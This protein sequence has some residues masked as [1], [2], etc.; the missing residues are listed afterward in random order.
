MSDKS[1]EI[2]F[3][4]VYPVKL[5]LG[6]LVF[7][8]NFFVFVIFASKRKRTSSD[9][10]IIPNLL[11]DFLH[12]AGMCIPLYVLSS[13]KEKMML[14]AFFFQVLMF[15]SLIM[16][17][18][19]TLNRYT[20]VLRPMKYKIWFA[21]T[22]MLST[23][24][25]VSAVT[26]FLFAAFAYA[27]FLG[28]MDK[29]IYKKV[30][31]RTISRSLSQP[32]THFRKRYTLDD[33]FGNNSISYDGYWNPPIAYQA[34]ENCHLKHFGKRK[35]AIL[36][37]KVFVYYIWPQFQLLLVSLNTL[38]MCFVYKKISNHFKNRVKLGLFGRFVNLVKNV[39]LD[40]ESENK[41]QCR[42]GSAGYQETNLSQVTKE[43]TKLE[44]IGEAAILT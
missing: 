8:A 27:L 33:L 35:T 25:A 29:Q 4:A 21:K 6:V 2:I 19:M 14:G 37:A 13:N 34:Y 31:Y 44:K 5:L 32:P 12:G 22:R 3:C 28:T 11:V 7:I 41:D 42:I 36:S 9:Y 15:F 26:L 20:A 40:D 18:M 16:L 43:P 23:F 1:R 39:F 10:L 30:C 24:V 38:L 17:F